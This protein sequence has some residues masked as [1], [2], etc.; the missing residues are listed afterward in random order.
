[1]STDHYSGHQHAIQTLEEADAMLLSGIWE[2]LLSNGYVSQVAT[3]K[4]SSICYL[5]KG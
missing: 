5:I 3:F 2:P 1:M 4:L